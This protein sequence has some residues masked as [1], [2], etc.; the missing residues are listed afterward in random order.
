MGLEFY[1]FPQALS[2]EFGVDYRQ[3]PFDKGPTLGLLIEG[4]G[5]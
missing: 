4:V 3:V 2:G 1:T 5:S